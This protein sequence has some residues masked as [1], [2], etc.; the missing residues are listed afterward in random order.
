MT[1]TALSRPPA[2]RQA[3]RLALEFSAIW[4]AL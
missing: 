4:S 2:L 1:L 3:L